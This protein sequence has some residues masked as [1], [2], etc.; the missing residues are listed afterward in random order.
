MF[1]LLIEVQLFL[2]DAE[3]PASRILS[4]NGQDRDKFIGHR[5]MLRTFSRLARG[6]S[7]N[8]KETYL[9]TSGAF[10]LFWLECKI[11]FGYIA[12]K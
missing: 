3:S 4:V 10:S 5:V 9:G 6:C 8:R 11:H 2:S 1:F 7:M 12:S